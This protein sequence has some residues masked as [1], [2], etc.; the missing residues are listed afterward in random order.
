M[1]SVFLP[2]LGIQGNAKFSIALVLKISVLFSLQDNIFI[3]NIAE[4][5]RKAMSKNVK[6]SCSTLD[7]NIFI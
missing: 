3:Y 7:W 2:P 6:I 5:V 4:K 1:E